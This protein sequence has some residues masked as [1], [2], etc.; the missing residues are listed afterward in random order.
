M[1]TTTLPKL[2]L[3]GVTANCDWIPAP[4][5]P[6]VVGELLALFT[7]EMLPVALPAA[8]GAKV[9]LKGA[10]CPAARV[11]GVVIPLAAKPLPVALTWEMLRLVVPEFFTVTVCAALLVPTRTFPKLR[12]V[13]DE[14][15]CPVCTPPP[16][17]L[18]LSITST[19]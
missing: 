8:V 17:L 6:I 12:L 7:T 1:P 16:E 3:A 18:L 5:K 2:A 4:L 14:V 13:G 19:Q 11:N 10:L 9:T 15:S